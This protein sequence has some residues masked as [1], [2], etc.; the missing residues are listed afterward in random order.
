MTR[1]VGRATDV[2]SV[3]DLV[4][5][6]AIRLVT[7]TGPGGVGK[8]RL[9][10]AI[11][12]DLADYF[13]DG[14][15]WVELA[16][17]QDPSLVAVTVLRSLRCEDGGSHPPS[18]V[19]RIIGDRKVLLVIDN[20]E[21]L[22]AASPLLTDLLTACPYLKILV[23][24]RTR[25][26]LRGEHEVPVEP[27]SLP[28]SESLPPISILPSFGAI[29]LWSDRARAANAAF[30]LTDSNA[31]TVTAICQ[32][33]DGL[34]LAIELAAAR[35]NALTPVAILGRLQC[36][37]DLLVDGP[38]DVPGRHQTMY[39]AIA[40]SYDLLTPAE[41]AFFRRLSVFT[42]SFSLDAAEAVGGDGAG[43]EH[44]DLIGSL[45]GKSL[46]RSLTSDG[47][48][49]Y[50][51]L[52]TVRAFGVHQLAASGEEAAFRTR[53]A[54]W[55]LA[56]AERAAPEL[57]GPRQAMWYDRLESELANLR[58]ALEWLRESG[59]FE[60]SLRLATGV[61]WFW[62]SRGY[63]HEAR[64]A[65]ESLIAMP[66][67][68]QNPAALAF[69]LNCAADAAHW[70]G[71]IERAQNNFE[72]AIEIYRTI[73]DRHGLAMALRGLGSVAIEAN[74]ARAADLL[75]EALA[76]A[77]DV[78]ADW[79]FAGAT[80]LLGIVAFAAG[81][82]NRAIRHQQD[83]LHVWR[84]L[85]DIAYVAGAL[86]YIGLAWLESGRYEAARSSYLEALGLAVDS[87]DRLNIARVL[88]G[89][90]GLAAAGGN[91]ENG[92]LLLGAADA[93]RRRSGMSRRPPTIAAI[94]RIAEIARRRLDADAFE[95][96]REQGRSLGQDE[97]IAL[98][99]TVLESTSYAALAGSIP[100]VGT[101]GQPYLS[102]RETEVLRLL[103]EGASDP[104]IAA[105]LFIS[106]YTA[107]NHVHAIL[108]KLGVANRAAAV[109]HAIRS[110]LV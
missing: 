101:P 72:R 76:V 68:G 26:R 3:I 104:E 61:G 23:T 59:D 95:S 97:A 54:A 96:A 5:D 47:E 34:P 71:D 89:S 30:A 57:D 40:W 69:A 109:A 44:V 51:M 86:A 36:R 17:L 67:S 56:L 49:R 83:A 14:V 80:H 103:T 102:A 4:R 20:F 85:G 37:L 58:A 45:V 87:Q 24:S 94:D 15:A 11:A 29:Q 107:S 22:V 81:D 48:P 93:S 82:H 92:A 77:R 1:L 55:Y 16:S 88:E 99:R 35:S 84:R 98:A 38:R 53:H 74:Q 9:A 73:D 66:A 19:L 10:L 41:Q 13:A 2:A 18:E 8:T 106:R 75:E 25:L 79:Y 7:L 28:D 27:L 52:E 46:I 39:A 6:P 110:G 65:F 63:F 12:A 32:R 43:A 78:G 91:A 100:G 21:H 62:T 64:D 42:G 108:T 31:A 105:R 33:L 70:L 90:A 50:T 60:T